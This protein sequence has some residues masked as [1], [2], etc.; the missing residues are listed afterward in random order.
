M[1]APSAYLGP[2][3]AD[4]RAHL[5]IKLWA[6]CEVEKVENFTGG[7]KVTILKKPRYAN[8]KTCTGCRTYTEKCQ[9]KIGFI[10][11]YLNQ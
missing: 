3:M 8:F 1:I 11:I 4:A 2:K 9:I 7:F 10:L 5:N 6:Y